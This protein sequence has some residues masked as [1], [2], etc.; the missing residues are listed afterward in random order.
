VADISNIDQIIEIESAVR[1]AGFEPKD[2]IL[3]GLGGLL[4]SRDKTRDAVSAGYKLTMADGR[5]TGKLSND[6]GKEAT[7]GT[8]NIEI[9]DGVRW[10][11]QEDEPQNGIRVLKKVYENGELYFT[12]NSIEAIDQARACAIGS[13]ARLIAC[14]THK[15]IRTKL[16]QQQVRDRFM[17]QKI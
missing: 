16:L 6:P 4:V 17:A 2:Y 1:D 12:G 15:S 5:A 8:L 13:R 3:Y 14:P 9:R 10:I 7:P 11:V